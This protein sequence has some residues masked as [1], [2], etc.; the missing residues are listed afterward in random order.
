MVAKTG[1]VRNP[2]SGRSVPWALAK[3]LQREA[4]IAE[5]IGLI[6]YSIGNPDHL[7]NRP[8]G[9]HT[10]WRDGSPVGVVWA[11]DIMVD[12][13]GKDYLREFEQFAIRYCKS[14]ADT[15]AIRFFNV[16]GSQYKFNGI[17]KWDSGDHHFHLEIENGKQN[18]NLGLMAAW[19]EYKN[20]TTPEEFNRLGFIDDARL[21]QQTGKPEVWLTGR[22]KKT[23]VPNPTRL[24]VIQA[25]MKAR[26][27]PSNVEQ[28]S[29]PIPGTVI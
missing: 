13:K 2:F 24:K 28:S 18:A 10:P 9:G 20:P 8:A 27:I 16:N 19:K 11:I 1:T 26:G 3:C 29:A 25:F 4:E 22:G 15:T 14:D 7:D 6:V 17:R 21:K 23:H 5:S 12:A